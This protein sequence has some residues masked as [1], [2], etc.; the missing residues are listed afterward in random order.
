MTPEKAAEASSSAV[1]ESADMKRKSSKSDLAPRRRRSGRSGT[2]INPEWTDTDFAQAKPAAEVPPD[3]VGSERAE[4]LLR[5]RGRPKTG[6]ARTLISLRLPPDTLARWK[7]TG[8][9]W[10][11]RMADLLGRAVRTRGAP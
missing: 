3:L 11:T 10:Q 2:G 5:P 7:A 9:G 1:R 8:P 4:R 6:N